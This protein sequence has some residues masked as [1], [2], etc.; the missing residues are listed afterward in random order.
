LERRDFRIVESTMSA[1]RTL[2]DALPV[3]MIESIFA[4]ASTC[5]CRKGESL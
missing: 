5:R 2:G 4:K 3:D 1:A